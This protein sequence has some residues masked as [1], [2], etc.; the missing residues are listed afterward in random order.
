[1]VIARNT[2]FPETKTDGLGGRRLVLFTSAHGHYSMTKAAQMFGLGSSA[3]RAVPVDSAGRMS[4]PALAGLVRAAR[5]AGE[6]PFFVNAT[7]GTTV[8]GAF[9][10]LDA[11]A[12]VCAREGLWL[13]VDGSWGGCVA[14]DAESARERLRGVHRADS[15]A[16]TPH[17][18]LQV[19]LTCSFLLGRDMRKF[20]SAMTLPAG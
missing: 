5:A 1:M 17:K 7:A 20:R 12:D 3:A 15:V 2:L 18:M 8:L 11:V 10:P 14:F 9:D 16:V 19:P 6:L 4:A 13:H